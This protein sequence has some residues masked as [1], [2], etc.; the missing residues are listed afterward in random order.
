MSLEG[1]DYLKWT[2]DGKAVTWAWGAQFFRQPID[3]TEPQ[4]TDVVV[5]L[6]RSRPKG[7]VLLT[8]ARIITMKGTEV[9]PQGDVL[10]TD[11]RIAAVGKRGSLT[12]PAGTRTINVAARRSCRASSTRTRTCGRRA[13]C[14][15]PRCG[16]T[17][18][19]SPT[20]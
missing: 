16:S 3:A 13:G 9:I 12:A 8:G 11:N 14:I 17:W 2:A 10:V 4:K 18:P 1:G 5:E 19:T 15:K 6:P 7:S 20:A